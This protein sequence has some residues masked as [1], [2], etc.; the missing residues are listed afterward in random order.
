MLKNLS[1]P[2]L[3]LSGTTGPEH[4]H[5]LGMMEL[6][7]VRDETASMTTKGKPPTIIQEGCI[8]SVVHA[9]P[10]GFRDRR[11]CGIPKSIGA[12]GQN[13]MSAEPASATPV[14]GTPELARPQVQQKHVV[15]QGTD[16]VVPKIFL[17][18]CRCTL[19]TF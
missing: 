16:E 10:F 12:F 11:F 3:S 17:R 4:T 19:E 13:G 7:E 1:S 6:D 14:Q 2:F 18:V 9:L 15:S 8:R 5:M